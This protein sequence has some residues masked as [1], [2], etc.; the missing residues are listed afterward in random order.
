MLRVMLLCCLMLCYEFGVFRYVMLACYVLL[1]CN[2]IMFCYVVFCSVSLCCDMV[3]L[4]L[5]RNTM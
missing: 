5:L 3:C 1:L 2:V 4:V